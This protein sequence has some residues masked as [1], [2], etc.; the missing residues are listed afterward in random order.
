MKWTD[1]ELTLLIKIIKYYERK[2]EREKKRTMKRY[3]IKRKHQKIIAKELQK[4]YNLDKTEA[5]LLALANSEYVV[6]DDNKYIWYYNRFCEPPA[7]HCEPII[8]N[9]IRKEFL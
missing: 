7:N 5:S 8:Y 3:H 1:D 6:S 4:R 2:K 9:L